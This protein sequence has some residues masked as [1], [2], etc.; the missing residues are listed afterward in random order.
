MLRL[1]RKVL[2]RGAL[3]PIQVSIVA[4]EDDRGE[5]V[6]KR[7]LLRCDGKNRD[8]KL[9]PGKY[10]LRS[11]EVP[12]GCNV[13]GGDFRFEIEPDHPDPVCVMLRV[14]TTAQV[15][16]AGMGGCLLPGLISIKT[17]YFEHVSPEAFDHESKRAPAKLEKVMAKKLGG[18]N[19][20]L[21]HKTYDGDDDDDD[22]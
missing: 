15:L 12:I 10:I 18:T 21:H 5:T 13:Q 19:I 8:F 6:C 7:I 14:G 17:F 22:D 20:P 16:L 2:A 1:Q 11:R 3:Y 9:K 4:I